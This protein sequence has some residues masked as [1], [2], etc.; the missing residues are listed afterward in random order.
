MACAPKRA[1]VAGF[2]CGFEGA[3]VLQ[4]VD[5]FGQHFDLRACGEGIHRPDQGMGRIGL[6]FDSE[7][8]DPS[9]IGGQRRLQV[10]KDVLNVGH[11]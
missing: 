1:L 3:A 9:L 4:R 10:G 5:D 8:C 2:N 6:H 11:V 7:V